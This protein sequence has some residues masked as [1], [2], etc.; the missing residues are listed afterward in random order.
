MTWEISRHRLILGLNLLDMIPEKVGLSS[1]E[2]IWIR[3]KGDT[4]TISVASYIMGEI[5]LTGKGSW[6]KGDFY[7]DRRVL[8]PFIYA[9]R[10]LKNKNTFQFEI[11]KHQLLVRHGNR[12]AVF[13]SQKDVTGYGNLKRVMKEKETTIPVSD[14]L[15]EL[16]SCGANCAVSDAIVP[17]LNCVYINKNNVAIE[18]YAASDKVF[19]MG[20]GNIEKDKVKSSIPFPLFLINLLLEKSLNKVSWYGKYIVM[21]FDK[22]IIW[23]SISQ[24]AVKNFPIKKIRKFEHLADSI[25]VTFTISS[26]RLAKTMVRLAYYL[27]AVRRRDWVVHINGNKGI[28]KLRLSVHI[29][30]VNFDETLSI[31]HNLTKEVKLIWPLDILEQVFAF[32]SIHTKK[33]GLVVREDVRH[34]I[35]YLRIGKLW[36][37]ITSKVE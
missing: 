27:Q 20:M 29:P 33:Q 7:I 18:A 32:L 14:D 6:P 15:K 19:F 8:L 9:S 3:G 37:A 16:L 5:Q 25:P 36:F 30:G 13:D 35:S 1:S 31:T 17:N 4:I 21:H 12:K 34:G 22:G 23:Q 28:N 2:F 24:E 10:E 26:R 11:K